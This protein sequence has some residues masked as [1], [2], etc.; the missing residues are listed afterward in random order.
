MQGVD[1]GEAT[2]SIDEYLREAAAYPIPGVYAI[3][4]TKRSLQYVG[5]AEDVVAQL[6]VRGAVSLCPIVLLYDLAGVCDSKTPD[7]QPTRWACSERCSAYLQE[8]K[9]SVD[10][11]LCSLVRVKLF[12]NAS[13]ATEENLIRE[14]HHWIQE[15]GGVMPPGN[16]AEAHLWSP[17]SLSSSDEGDQDVVHPDA[18][19]SPFSQATVSVHLTRYRAAAIPYSVQPSRTES[20]SMRARTGLLISLS[21]M[22]LWDDRASKHYPAPADDTIS[23]RT[24]CS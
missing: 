11:D 22:L 17:S 23:D 21:R 1:E 4:D 13:M 9:A 20:C 7:Q 5:A 14:A 12:A 16:A 19:V 2:V 15:E 3:Y 24:V 10:E 6:K 18:K 8:H